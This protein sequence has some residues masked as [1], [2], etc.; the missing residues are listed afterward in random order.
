VELR[1]G[2][3]HKVNVSERRNQ[4]EWPKEGVAKP[5]YVGKEQ[6]KELSMKKKIQAK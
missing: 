1:T 2:I 4:K 5:A 6:G 3:L